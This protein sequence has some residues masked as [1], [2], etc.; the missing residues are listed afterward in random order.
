[1]DSLF[2]AV[3][4]HL[5][6]SWRVSARRKAEPIT[7]YKHASKRGEDKV[8]S[9]SASSV[10]CADQE[11]ASCIDKVRQLQEGALQFGYPEHLLEVGIEDIE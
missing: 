1:M 8:G 6:A 7:T 2:V 11:S 9:L 4:T 3:S 10:N 5:T